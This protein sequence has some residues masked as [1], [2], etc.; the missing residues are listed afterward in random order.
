MRQIKYVVFH[1]TGA[2]ATQKVDVIIDYWKRVKG[3]S[4][5]GYHHLIEADGTVHDLAPIFET[6]NGVAGY[7]SSSIHI[8]YIGGDN[9]QDT[10]TP[11]Q[12]AA[13]SRLAKK[14][15]LMFPSAK[16]CGHRDFSPDKNNNG[17]IDPSEYI[18]FCPAFEVSTWLKEIGL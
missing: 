5:V 4:K 12:K 2:P 17:K 7:N 8:C 13:L 15:K 16:F 3:W 10:R 6:T 14:Y 9:W 1:C 18:K 11:A